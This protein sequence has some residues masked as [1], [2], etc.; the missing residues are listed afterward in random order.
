MV[1]SDGGDV[2]L[3]GNPQF[4]GLLYAPNASLVVNGGGNRD[5]IVGGVVV[6]D[7]T[8]NGN[9]NVVHSNPDGFQVEF[10]PIDTITYLHVSENRVSIGA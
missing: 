8:A 1:H 9:G 2:T 3:N 4:T 10:E 7:A 6:R 5:N